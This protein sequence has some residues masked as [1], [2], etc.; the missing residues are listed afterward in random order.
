MSYRVA[1]VPYL[2]AKPLVKPFEWMGAAT[3]VHVDFEVPSLLPDRLRVG[4]AEA[5]MVSSV[6]AW[7]TPG[8]RVAANLSISTQREVL[9]VRLFSKVPFN[10]IR[11]V[12]WD[13]SSLTS[14]GLAR[15]LLRDAY[16]VTPTGASEPP[17]QSTMLAHHYACV[18]IGGHGM[19]GSEDG[20]YVMDMGQAWHDLT[21]LPF[22]WAL[23]VGGTSLSRELVGHL[24]R[25]LD[26]SLI[27]MEDVIAE[28]SR[29][30][31]F[32]IQQ[33]R[34]YLLDIMDYRLTEL[35][36]A[37]LREFGRRLNALGIL[38]EVHEPQIIQAETAGL[39]LW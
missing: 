22:V 11:S 30:T 9:S 1:S 4:D 6:Y 25:A 17:V 16:G 27:R 33:C 14:N 7:A 8:A 10:E 12:A 36:V 19:A 3:P 37:G 38:E 23:W 34:H 35:H 28:S 2:N 20:L 31:G 39:T 24:Q 26:E 13:Q 21:G 18:L 5:I 15:I 32:S 29:E